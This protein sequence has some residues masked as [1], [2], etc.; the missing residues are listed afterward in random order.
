MSTH[1]QGGDPAEYPQASIGFNYDAVDGPPEEQDRAYGPMNLTLKPMDVLLKFIAFV[2]DSSDPLREIDVA[3]AAIGLP[4]HQGCSY[5]ALAKKHAISKQA[6]DKHVLRFQKNFQ[7]PVT[8]AQKSPQARASYRKT[9]LDRLQRLAV[10]HQKTIDQ[11][12][13]ERAELVWQNSLRK[14]PKEP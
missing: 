7:L 10:I 13:Q 4:I 9:Q 5:T 12:Q 6:F 3:V 2:V 1:Y 8:R 14:V 11:Q